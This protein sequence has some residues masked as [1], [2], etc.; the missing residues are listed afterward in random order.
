[1]AGKNGTKPHMLSADEIFNADD[2]RRELVHVSLWKGDVWV[3]ALTLAEQDI[4]R[5]LAMSDDMTLNEDVNR[6][7]VPMASLML[8]RTRA[9]TVALGTIQEDG[10]PMFTLRDAERLAQK[11]NAAVD[12]LFGVIVR[13]TGLSSTEIEELEGNSE[14]A[15]SGD[16]NSD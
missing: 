1:M 5:S 7:R 8:N 16:S 13:L 4:V 15:P 12:Q 6:I 10:T 3:R 11:A 9:Q 14:A 2:L